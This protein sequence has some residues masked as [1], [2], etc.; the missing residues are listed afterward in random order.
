[1]T[2]KKEWFIREKGE[3][4]YE[5]DLLHKREWARRNPAAIV[6]AAHEHNR[7][8]GKYYEHKK[9]YQMTGIPGERH[10]IRTIHGKQYRHFKRI[11][12]PDSVMHHEWIPGTADFRGVALVE[13]DQ[14]QYGIIDVIQMLDGDITLLTEKEVRGG[15]CNG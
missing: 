8:G 5:V 14:H 11:I 6:A 9:H 15:Y 12:A 10:L 1:V 13:K 7:K 4:A 2:I 3:E